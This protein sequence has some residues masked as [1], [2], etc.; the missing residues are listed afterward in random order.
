MSMY[1]LLPKAEGA[2]ALKNFRDNLTTEII[3]YLI[4]N[5]TN[6]TCIIGLPRMKLSST[7]KLNE[8]LKSMGLRSLFDPRTADL[9]VLSSG[10]GSRPSAAARRGFATPQAASPLPT[11][12]P[13]S[14][15]R[16][17]QAASPTRAK[18]T[19]NVDYYPSYAVPQAAS[20]IPTALPSSIPRVPQTTSPTGTRPADNNDYLIFS[21]VSEDHGDQRATTNARNNRFRYEDKQRG[22]VVEQWGT[23]FQLSKIRRALRRRDTVDGRNDDASRATYVTTKNGE[24]A[25]GGHESTKYVSLEENKYRFRDLAERRASREKRQIRPMDENFLSFIRSQN[26]TSYGLDAQRN[27]GGLVNPHLFADEIVHKVEME[28][29]ERG[30]E[31]AAAT[32]VILHRDGNQKRLMADRP[33]LFFI[34]HD[35]TKLILFWGTVNTPTPN[36]TAR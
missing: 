27:S 29:T 10:H 31:A 7:L 14:I 17:P 22:V 25:R 12:L 19:G 33:F 18:P 5:L 24:L 20:P 26:F 1:V 30:T 32:A 28:V 8:A 9:S 21:R 16:V 11:A 23:G 6:Q 13:P 2:A 15:P 36:Y 4:G 3:E 35:P 34:R